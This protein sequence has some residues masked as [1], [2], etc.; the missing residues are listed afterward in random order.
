NNPIAVLIRGDHEINEDKLKRVL[1][2]N[3]IN[4]ANTKFL[5]MLDLTPG[6]LGPVNLKQNIKIIADLSVLDIC[7]ALT[8]SNKS[9][10]HLQNV[11]Y[12][13]DY[14]VDIIADIRKFKYNDLCPQC[15][16]SI[17]D[18][19]KGIEIGHT[20]KLDVK[21]SKL[22]NGTY[23]NKEGKRNLMYMGC[24]GI[25]VTRLLVAIV[26]QC[27]DQDG[28]IW[29]KLIAPFDVIIIPIN[30]NNEYIKKI[31]KYLCNV[32]HENRLEVLVDDRQAINIR[33]RLKDADLIGVPYRVIINKNF[34][35]KQLVELKCRKDKRNNTK[36]VHINHIIY[37]I[38]GNSD[39]K[40]MKKNF[41][42]KEKTN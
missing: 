10:Y 19:S 36:L 17:L 32:F 35:S 15:K 4:L 40:E 28:I 11:N 6:F 27:H 42:L 9:D 12:K 1:N 39:M 34:I 24:Y 5:H 29:P 3:N 22:M 25:G 16:M 8:G 23:V 37:E 18:V 26:E 20:F 7:N 2:T 30:F 38:L 31:I 33:S 13:R 14:T 21:Y 41:E